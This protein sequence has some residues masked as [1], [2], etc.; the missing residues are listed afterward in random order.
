RPSRRRSCFAVP[1]GHELP[2]GTAS[3]SS[4][5]AEVRTTRVAPLLLSSARSRGFRSFVQLAGSYVVNIAGDR[6]GPG[7]QRMVANAAH[8][9]GRNNTIHLAERQPVKDPANGSPEKSRCTLPTHSLGVKSPV[10]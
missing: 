1:S 7:D 2:P 9:L 5:V 4:F 3:R 6:N 8:E 10:A